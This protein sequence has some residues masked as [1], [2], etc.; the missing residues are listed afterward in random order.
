MVSEPG[1]APKR[2]RIFYGWWL[3]G[4]SL[5]LTGMTSGAIWGSVGV[6]LKTL[7]LHF[8]W[9]RTQMTGAFS[10]AQLEGSIVGPLAGYFVDRLGP[11][12]MV[13]FGAV[14]VGLG[15]LLLSRTTNLPVFYVAFA[16][17]MLGAST[18]TWLPTMAAVSRWF[19]RRRATAVAIAAEGNYMGGLLLVPVLAW[20]V[21]PESFGWQVT[22]LGI[23]VVFLAVAAPAARVMRNRPE[24]YGEVPDGQPAPPAS[25]SLA[26]P[27][28]P[29]GTGGVPPPPRAI[30][31]TAAQAMR[32]QA[33]WLITFGHAIASMVNQTLSV[34]LVPLLTDQGLSLQMGANIWAV[35]MGAAMA[36]SLVAGYVGD[37]MP[38]NLGL[39]LFVAIQ[40]VGFGMAILIESIPLAVLMA[41]IYGIGFGGR[42]P[43]AVAIRADY[44]GQRA[45]A[46]ITGLSMAPMF[47]L[48][49][50]APLFAAAMFDWQGSYTIA[51]VV[52]TVL[53]V[54][55]ALLFLPATKPAAPP[56]ATP[57]TSRR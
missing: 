11:R 19:D 31:F 49:L 18:G 43:L 13:L 46:T 28:V 16:L 36:S 25:P 5:L 57:P 8:G 35:I 12:W 26:S 50:V 33:F 15:F 40:S 56:A 39:F 10:M 4:L 52:L 27:T 44:F 38:K 51:F 30:D 47:F 24:E 55:G 29:G 32:T 7:E 9:T 17:F 2:P 54:V 41:I 1:A 48:Q 21:G 45:F 34:H 37:R 3:V 20:A 53:G 14:V 22:A 6:W 23:G 42:N